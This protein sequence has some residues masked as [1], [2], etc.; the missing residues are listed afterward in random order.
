[1][2]RD[3]VVVGGGGGRELVVYVLWE[4]CWRN[5]ETKRWSKREVKEICAGEGGN[6]GGGGA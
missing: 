6:G 1:M 2:D 3:G 5:V 4:E